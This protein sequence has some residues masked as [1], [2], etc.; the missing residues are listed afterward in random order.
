VA[1]KIHNISEMSKMDLNCSFGRRISPVKTTIQSGSSVSLPKALAG[2]GL[3]LN[4]TSRF[5]EKKVLR[6]LHE[7]DVLNRM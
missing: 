7:Q 1:I 6:K 3:T 5:E 4:N 2:S